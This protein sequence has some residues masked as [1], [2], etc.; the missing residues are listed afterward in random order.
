MKTPRNDFVLLKKIE[1]EEKKQ[2][3]II[4]PGTV[5]NTFARGIV[6]AAGPGNYSSEGRRLPMDDLKPGVVVAYSKQAAKLREDSV[7]KDQA[8]VR[9]GE[10][11]LI[12]GAV[13]SEEV[14]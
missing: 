5:D 3:G 1:E 9:D 4:L 13:A 2:G 8:L 12:E 14:Q 6:V 7:P 11:Y 10:I